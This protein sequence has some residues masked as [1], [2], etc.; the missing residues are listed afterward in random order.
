[1]ISIVDY[2]LGNIRAFENIYRNL[3]IRAQVAKSATE[4]SNASK[5][6]L[7]GVGAFDWAMHRLNQSG[8]AETLSDLVLNQKVPV[9]GV[10]VGMQIMAKSSE[11]GD[12]SGL[13]WI[14][15]DVKRFDEEL[16][17]QRTHLPHMGWNDIEV[18]K[19]CCLFEGIDRPLFYFLHSYYLNPL[20]R[21]NVVGYSNYGSKFVCA[22][23][24][25]NIFATQFHPEKSHSSGIKL[26]KNFSEMC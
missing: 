19:N 20:K 18:A 25:G 4:L 26:L 22:I 5:I 11:E 8:M 16:F 15:A 2:G 24:E 1:M 14:D 10:C 7:P 6:I 3:G 21:Q 9:L 12:L 23:A 13:G 17:T